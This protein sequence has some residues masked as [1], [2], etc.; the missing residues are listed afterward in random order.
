MCLE[1]LKNASV[2]LRG[3]GGWMDAALEFRLKIYSPKWQLNEK[4]AI[5]II[6]ITIKMTNNF[7]FLV[8]T[9]N[10]W[11]TKITKF[12]GLDGRTDGLMEIT[13]CPT[14]RHPL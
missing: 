5:D 6:Q 12:P 7:K 8:A 9:R 10:I 11:S 4:F 13:L 14:K 1:D 3:Q 2:G